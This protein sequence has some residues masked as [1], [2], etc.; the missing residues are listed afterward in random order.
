MKK[1]E[2]LP[3]SSFCVFVWRGVRTEASGFAL[4][5]HGSVVGLLLSSGLGFR[6]ESVGDPGKSSKPKHPPNSA[7]F[8]CRFE[9]H[10]VRNL[11]F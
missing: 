3:G 4:V 11:N 2:D 7:R 6:R 5:S 1:E 8:F 9:G 10:P